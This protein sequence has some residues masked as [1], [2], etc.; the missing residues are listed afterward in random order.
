M[1]GYIMRIALSLVPVCVLLG[2]CGGPQSGQ[3]N[4]SQANIG[5][6]ASPPATANGSATN[7]LIMLAAGPVQ[8]AQAAKV[9]H[10]RHE[11]M[12]AIGKANKAIH[13]ELD[14]ASP[15]LATVKTSAAQIAGLSKKASGWFPKGT[16]PDVGKTGAKPE[17][18]QTPQDFAAKLHAFQVAAQAFNAAA[19]GK[20]TNAIKARYADLGGTCK[21]CHD[22][23]RSEMKH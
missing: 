13:R 17:I 19:A 5:N 9:M 21:A 23:Y 7:S 22:K 10:E 2:A 20:D 8:G 16:G 4:N 3:A 14:S 15:N 11:G 6:D 12:E 1:K 18:W